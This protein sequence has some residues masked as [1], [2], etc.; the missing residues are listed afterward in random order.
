MTMPV[1][2][3]IERY[4]ELL[5]PTLAE[6]TQAELDTRLRAHG[7]LFGGRPLC[8]VLR[9]RMI[10]AEQYVYLR[11]ACALVLAAL[12]RALRAALDSPALLAQFRLEPWEHELAAFDPGFHDASPTSRLD[13]FM[14]A[15]GDAL[16]FTEYNAETPAGLAYGDALTELFLSLPAVG[17]FLREYELRPLPARHALLFPL[18]EAYYS[19]RGVRETPRIAIVDWRDV[20]TASE[21]TLFE[22]YFHD[23]GIPCTIADPREVE[24]RNGRLVHGDFEI[25]LIYKRVLVSELVERGGMDHPVLRAVRERAACMVNPARCKILHKKASLAVLSDERNAHLFSLGQ[26]DAIGTHVPWT[27]VVEERETEKGGTTIDL[28]PWIAAHRE[29]LVLKP[30]DAYGGAGIVLGWEVDDTT[31]RRAVETALAEPFIVQERI[32]LPTEPY[33]SWVDGGVQI[34]DRMLDVAPFVAYGRHV[35]GCLSRLGTTPLLNVTAGGG[36]TVPSFI[37][38]PR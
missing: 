38:A 8:T 14:D 2:R 21:F 26:L 4:H 30:N 34:V 31:W 3:A 23:V 33:P 17:P 10:G 25:T 6:E 32:R 13:A 18:L 35:E 29:H 7:L 22:R 9:P 1:R 20:P 27:R 36:S 16:W 11:R 19:W 37:V 5:T 28:V 12:S 24:Y 15:E